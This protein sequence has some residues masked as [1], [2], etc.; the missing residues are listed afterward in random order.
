MA[1]Q[2]AEVS[3]TNAETGGT[4]RCTVEPA[5]MAERGRIKSAERPCGARAGQGRGARVRRLAAGGVPRSDGGWRFRHACRRTVHWT[6]ARARCACA[7]RAWHPGVT[8]CQAKATHRRTRHSHCRNTPACPC[9][10]GVPTA[11]LHSRSN[12][13]VQFLSPDARL[14]PRT[15][16]GP[17]ARR[18]SGRG[19]SRTAEPS[20]ALC[21]AASSS[22]EHAGVVPTRP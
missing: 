2:D 8:G 1:R 15:E 12:R 9:F 20:L 11:R 5:G 13:G 6:G 18:P 3:G 10:R 19:R 7:V 21:A 4:I 16:P 17:T 14:N 22:R